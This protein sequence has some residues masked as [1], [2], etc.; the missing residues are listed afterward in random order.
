MSLLPTGEGGQRRIRRE[1]HR[2][3][4]GQRELCLTLLREVA[5]HAGKKPAIVPPGCSGHLV[6]ASHIFGLTGGLPAV[7]LRTGR[8]AGIEV[9]MGRDDEET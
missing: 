7:V 5:F 2:R 1:A 8:L 4:A 9:S 3:R 6:Q